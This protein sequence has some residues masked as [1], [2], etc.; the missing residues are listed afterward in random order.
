MNYIKLESF[1][2]TEKTINK[3][4]R[5]SHRAE[6]NIHKLYI[7]QGVNVQNAY[8]LKELSFTKMS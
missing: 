2:T 6:E 1:F 3:A 8:K 7:G 5:K 4:K